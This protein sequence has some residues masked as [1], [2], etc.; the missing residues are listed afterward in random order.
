MKETTFVAT[1]HFSAKRGEWVEYERNYHR[2]LQCIYQRTEIVYHAYVHQALL[3]RQ[4]SLRLTLT[5]I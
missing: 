3:K 1:N 2:E 5:G 4:C